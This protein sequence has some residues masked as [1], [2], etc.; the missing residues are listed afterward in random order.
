MLHADENKSVEIKRLMMLYTR[1]EV[2]KLS[3]TLG[4]YCH[5]VKTHITEPQ[6]RVS[7]SPQRVWDVALEFASLTGSQMMIQ[8]V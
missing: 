3:C 1:H 2:F 7:D 4:T 8:L 6:P 5:L